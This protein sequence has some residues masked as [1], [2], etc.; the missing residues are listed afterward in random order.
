MGASVPGP[1]KACK[2]Q[3]LFGYIFKFVVC[4][5]VCVILEPL[6]CM[7]RGDHVVVFHVCRYVYIYMYT[8]IHTQICSWSP[9][10]APVIRH[11]RSTARQSKQLV[12][13]I[14]LT[15]PTFVQ[16][17]DYEAAPRLGGPK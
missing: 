1:P 4:V 9:R 2:T 7:P 17:L 13:L 15:A 6:C 14:D 16:E 10:P 12:E 3:P 5:C 8:H 11:W